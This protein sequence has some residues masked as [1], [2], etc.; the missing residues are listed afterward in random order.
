MALFAAGSARAQAP[1]GAPPPE[2]K[3]AVA[4]PKASADAPKIAAPLD[5][6]NATISAGGMLATGNSRQLATTANVAFD[7]RFSSNAIGFSVLA[8]YGQG[9]PAGQPIET[10][11]ENAQ[12]RVRYDRY[13]IEQASFFL[14]NTLRHDRLQGLKVRYN[15]DPGFKYIFW[16]D[17]GDSAWG[18]GG[19]DLQYDVRYLDARYVLDANKNRVVDATGTQYELLDKTQT[20]HSLRLFG[21]FKYAFNKAVTLTTGLEFLQSFVD[22]TRYRLNFDA[23]FAASLGAGLSLGLGEGMRYDHDALPGKEKLDTQTTLNLIFAFSDIAEPPKAPTCPCPPPPPPPPVEA[24]P[25]PAAPA[26]PSSNP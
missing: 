1:T 3:A 6:T 9:A 12:G 18:E 24:A 26:A 7:T 21:G 19:Y 14:I 25:A 13:I 20:D 2:A 15:L 23:V 22:S 8:N 11:T 17:G 16:Q 5:G 4:A 10:T